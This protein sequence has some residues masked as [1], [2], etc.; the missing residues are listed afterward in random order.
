MPFRRCKDTSSRQQ[1]AGEL[2]AHTQAL[3]V[4]KLHPENQP[5]APPVPGVRMAEAP[6]G[7]RCRPPGGSVPRRSAADDARGPA[8]AAQRPKGDSPSGAP[9]PPGNGRDGARRGH[10]GRSRTRQGRS[11]TDRPTVPA[12]LP[13]SFLGARRGA[14]HRQ[15]QPGRRAEWGQLPARKAAGAVPGCLPSEEERT[16]SHCPL[17]GNSIPAET[18]QSPSLIP[19]HLPFYTT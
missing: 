9:H 18:S 5:K 13:P 8:A 12:S 10:A 14:R 19:W 15:Q 3:A 7:A 1:L 4:P 11:G 2:Q 16:P 6:A 17:L